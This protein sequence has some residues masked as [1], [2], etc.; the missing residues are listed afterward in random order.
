MFILQILFAPLQAGFSDYCRKASLIIALSCSFLSILPIFSVFYFCKSLTAI[1]FILIEIGLVLAACLGNVTPIAWSALADHKQTNIRFSL[2]LTT[3]AYAI[4]Y[5]V[6]A[7]ANKQ[8]P[9]TSFNTPNPWNILIPVSLLGISITLVSMWY[10][11]KKHP[12][13]VYRKELGFFAHIRSEHADFLKELRRPA[14]FLGI[15][16]YLF[17]AS[18]QYG[19]LVWLVESQIYSSLVIIMMCGDFLGV[20]ILYFSQKI[21]D[22]KIIR[23]AFTVTVFSFLLFFTLISFTNNESILLAI[24]YFLYTLAN[25][26]LSPTILTLFSKERSIHEQGKGFGLIVSADTAGYLIGIFS[27][28]AFYQFN[29][30][31]KYMMLFSLVIFLISWPFYFEYEK[32]RKNAPRENSE[33]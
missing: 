31:V 21:S 2:A 7:F 18:S 20:I 8:I 11:D 19:I 17:W 30:G 32:R 10:H 12:L 16:A 33:Y 24:S 1:C 26:I 13:R 5:M 14:T 27:A 9:V 4:G 25:G 28:R 15:F 6:L 3:T 23:L 29:V 22:E